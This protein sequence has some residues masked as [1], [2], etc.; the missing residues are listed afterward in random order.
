MLM[1]MVFFML[2][3]FTQFHSVLPQ[4][5]NDDHHHDHHH[6]S[7][8]HLEED[9]LNSCHRS[10]Y[11]NDQIN[12]CSHKTHITLNEDDCSFCDIHFQTV[13]EKPSQSEIF[14]VYYY[15]S[16]STIHKTLLRTIITLTPPVRGP[17]FIQ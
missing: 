5:A 14:S 11:H 8:T 4:F 3:S 1:G 16:L 15:K 6:S 13:A 9:E 2:L 10:L 7:V 17:P 12:G